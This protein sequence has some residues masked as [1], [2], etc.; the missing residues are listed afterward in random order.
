MTYDEI[1]ER[2]KA[3]N[4]DDA[5]LAKKV[6]YWVFHAMRPLTVPELQHALAVEPEDPS[7]DGDSIPDEDLMVSV[8]A[9]IVAVQRESNTVG[10][11]H[12]TTQEYFD[13]KATSYFPEAQR[14]ILR[15]CL[16]YLSFQEFERGPCNSDKEV[17]T[18]LQERPL[19][20]YASGHWGRHVNERLEES[21]ETLILGF[22][23]QGSKM[24]T[25]LQILHLKPY[26]LERYTPHYTSDPSAL[27]LAA[28]FGLSRI[29]KLLL[30]QGV[31]DDGNDE[32]GIKPFELAASRGHENMVRLLLG[33]RADREVNT[34]FHHAAW[35]GHEAVMRLLLEHG[36]DINAAN[37]IGMTALHLA[38]R[39]GYQQL[40]RFLFEKGANI[41]LT[42]SHNPRTLYLAARSGNS[43]V[44]Q[45][46]LEHGGDYLYEAE[47]YMGALCVAYRNHHTPTVDI[48]LK[49]MDK[50]LAI[51]RQGRNPLHLA[52]AKEH[53][54]LVHRMLEKGLNPRD[55]DK[56][57]RTSLHHAAAGGSSEVVER[58]LEEGVDPAQ[59]D[60]DHW[61]PLH[62]AAR[63]GKES[64]IKIL[65][66]ANGDSVPGMMFRWEPQ[67]LRISPGQ[68]S[69]IQILTRIYDVLITCGSLSKL[70]DNPNHSQPLSLFTSVI[71]LKMKQK[72]FDSFKHLNVQ[73]DGCQLVS[74]HPAPFYYG[75]SSPSPP[76]LPPSLPTGKDTTHQAKK[77]LPPRFHVAEHHGYSPQVRR[78]RRF[79]LLLQMHSILQGNPPPTSYIPP[80][81]ASQF[82]LGGIS[83]WW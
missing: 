33:F 4:P 30:E 24:A 62:W 29:A 79:R 51:D 13:R 20:Q 82:F 52:S 77:K 54:G 45:V 35:S 9:G 31:E 46:L 7:L 63:A 27:W 65:V 76:P 32:F 81:R 44:I 41:A 48:L 83:W 11:V 18:R 68:V 66:N 6:V 57:K 1:W 19:L 64:N 73:C 71:V 67:S 23:G 70:V 75:S 14:E 72:L 43:A 55:L 8:C 10:L 50:A 26:K 25:S 74:D 61:T 5:D 28:Y 78:L 15:T 36:A 38:S 22:L 2:I 39:M 69:H 53:V 17:E 12:A 34:A 16:T 59:T 47:A 3:Q 80:L 21:E 58:L 42:T 56:Q 37:A 40:T 49:H 60:V